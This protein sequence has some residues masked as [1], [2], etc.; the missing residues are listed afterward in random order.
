MSVRSVRRALIAA[1]LG[2]VLA[3]PAAGAAACLRDDAAAQP[4][5]GVQA[6][7]RAYLVITAPDDTAH[8]KAAVGW[9][10][11][12]VYA[13]YDAIGVVVAH[14]PATG[15]ATR[16]RDVDGVQQVGATRTSDV[17]AEAHSPAIPPAQSQTRPTAPEIARYDMTNIGADLAWSVN[18]GSPSVTVGVLDTG[19]DD[20]HADLEGNFDAADSASCAYGR[21]D[22]RPGAWRPVGDHGTHV[23]GTIAAAKNGTG[24]AGVAPK[25]RIASVRVAEDPSGLFFAENTICAFVFAGDRG[26]DVTNSSFYT[27]PW[28][29][30]C[31]GDPDQAA[32]LEGVKRS[33]EYAEREGVLNVV[34]AGNENYDLAAKT[35]D[36]TSPNDSTAVTRRVT[37]DCLSL[38]AELPGVVT[39]A[40]LSTG[41]TKS[42][43]SNYGTGKVAIAAP[44]DN[45]Y[46][47]VPGGGYGS[48][49]GT[50]MAAP[51]VAGVAALLKSVT[52]SATPAQLRS[53][54]SAQADDLA[55]PPVDDRCSGTT[56]VNSF[57]G[58][59][60]VDAFQAVG[61]GTARAAGCSGQRLGNPSFETGSGWTFTAGVHGAF[62]QQPARSGRSIAWLNGYGRNATDTAGQAVAVPAGCS[63]TLTFW[64]KVL[65]SEASTTTAYDALTVTAGPVE[66]AAYS[67]LDRTTGWVQQ[68]VDLTPFAGHTV[69]LT[70]TGIEDYSL[71]TSFVLDDVAV[72]VH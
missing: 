21:V 18:R 69:T 38:P 53:R 67:N 60:R 45:V 36:P 6:G 10:G 63:T 34:A 29:F 31:P 9:N 26:L 16:M 72:T 12:T 8:A 15:F 47:T 39:V 48:K 35:A 7:L 4:V 1:A 41:N 24:M 2:L 46:S 52:P 19:V 66:L 3:A 62:A 59:G 23:A 28:L 32:I 42:D 58:E 54:L 20:Q 64:L 13:S 43:Y 55:C 5:T 17:P 37:T 44:G 33:V 49:S 30:A 40:A 51:H 71:Q 22:T 27:D 57:Y 14:A 61:S 50:S 68:S 65:S 70:F 11:G 25:V 56:G